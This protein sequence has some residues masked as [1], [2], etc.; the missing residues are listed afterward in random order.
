[1]NSNC[2]SIRSYKGVTYVSLENGAAKIIESDYSLQPFISNTGV[3]NSVS[4]HRGKLYLLCNDGNNSPKI[5]V[6]DLNGQLISSWSL[7]TRSKVLADSFVIVEDTVAVPIRGNKQLRVY[8]LEG[9]F[10][11]RINCPQ[12]STYSTHAICAVDSQSVVVSSL[13][14]SKVFRVNI[15]TEE[16]MWMT[17]VRNSGGV[18]RYSEDF[19]LVAVYESEGTT[20]SVLDVRTG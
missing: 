11:K 7:N 17:D 12:M 15:D 5:S 4:L 6:Y 10:I 14:T 3:V 9:K 13:G 20:I 19:I 1:M 8:S 18:T 2:Y 16:V